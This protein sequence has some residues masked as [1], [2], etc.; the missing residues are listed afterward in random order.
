[1]PVGE[2]GGSGT[3]YVTPNIDSIGEVNVITS[4]YNAEHGR[5]SSGLVQITTKSGTNQLRGS[6]WTNLRRDEWNKNDFFRKQAGDLKPFFEVNIGGYSI[7]GPVV[8][9]KVVDSR[10]SQKKFYFF[11][12]QEF[13]EDVRPTAVT[14]ANLPTELERNGDFS[15]TRFGK[16]TL[17]PDGSISG[18]QNL[19]VIRDPLTGQPFDGNKIPPD[20]FDPMGRALLLLAPLPNNVRDQTTNAYN[21]SNMA[22]DLT[23]QHTRTNFITRVDAVLGSNTRLSGR[24]L[25]DRDNAIGPNNI[26]PGVGEIN[27]NFPGNL[28]NG[29][30]TK[31]ISPSMVNETIVGYSWNHWGH[32]VGTGAAD[33]VQL[34][35]VVAGK[36]RQ[37]DHQRARPLPAADRG[38]WRVRRARPEGHEQ[39]RVAVSARAALHGR[40]PHQ[41]APVPSVGLERSAAEVEPQRA[42]H[43]QERPLL[44]AR[45]A[46]L[47]V[48]HGDGAQFQD[49]AGLAGLR[50]PV[51]LRAQRRQPDQLGQRLRQRAARGLHV[52]Q[53]TQR[54]DRPRRAALVWRVVRAG[55]L[56]ADVT[57]DVGLR[58]PHGTPRGDLRGPRRELG[59]RP[60]PVDG[61]AA[62]TLYRPACIGGALEL[63][64]GQPDCD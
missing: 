63:R 55:Q 29:T 64:L 38:V 18:A 32:R 26:A 13:T 37:P 62:P 61:G 11:L 53:R 24:A 57:A 33:P 2:E 43:G 56:A 7:G 58:L 20:R 59:L 49:R 9:P 1:M 22:L 12:S 17:N 34:H 35:A 31:V 3:T 52:V 28:I 39:G 44:H 41:P 48:R 19:N 36:R 5:Q 45:P 8:I 54:A 6:A 25:F 47:Q 15:Q 4:G 42:R 60:G 10:T 51:Q 14:R 46:Q 40:R 30:M 27:N 21:N 23:P 50:R 16:A